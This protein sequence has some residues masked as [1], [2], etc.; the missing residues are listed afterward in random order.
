MIGIL[1]LFVGRVFPKATVE[2]RTV[3]SEELSALFLVQL[4]SRNGFGDRATHDG[5]SSISSPLSNY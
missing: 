2:A 3:A 4:V 1:L 5:W